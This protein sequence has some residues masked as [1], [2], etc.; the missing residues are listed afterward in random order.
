[1]KSAVVTICSANHL[2]KAGVLMGSASECMPDYDRFVVLAEREEIAVRIRSLLPRVSGTPQLL[3]VA[4]IGLPHPVRLGFQYTVTEFNCALKPYAIRYLFKQGYE[5]VIYLDSDT[6]IYSRFA[7]VEALFAD[8]CDVIVTPHVTEPLPDDGLHPKND[9]ILRAGQFNGGF[10]GFKMGSGAD[11][12]LD[13]WARE[14]S[15]RA[16]IA[17]AR[18]TRTISFLINCSWISFQ[19]SRIV[20]RCLETVHTMS[21]TGT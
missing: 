15:T 18:M 13:Y 4:E 3:S 20:A 7:E 2:S 11:R 1:M 12:C 17:L 5:R 19:A 21:P 8:G 16:F 6:R 10:V 14:L 9:E